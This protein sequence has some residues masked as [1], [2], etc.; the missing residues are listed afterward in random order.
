MASYK[1]Y[2]TRESYVG[3]EH[4]Y[5]LNTHKMTSNNVYI[6]LFCRIG[7]DKITV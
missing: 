2:D 7:V 5:S 4:V 3:T 1:K 6:G